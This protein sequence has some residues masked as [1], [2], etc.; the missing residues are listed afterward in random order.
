MGPMLGIHSQIRSS[1]PR[2][3]RV[4][5]AVPATLMTGDTLDISYLAGLDG[6]QWFGYL[7]PEDASM[8]TRALV[9]TLDQ[10]MMLEA[11]CAAILTDQ[12]CV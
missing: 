1:G 2:H 6:Y 3:P 4:N 5:G 9:A 8:N 11:L 10:A 12:D 7:S